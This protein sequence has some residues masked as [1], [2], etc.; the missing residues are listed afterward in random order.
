[1]GNTSGD[2][3]SDEVLR[4]AGIERPGAAFAGGSDAENLTSPCPPVLNPAVLSCCTE[5]PPPKARARAQGDLPLPAGR[6]A[7]GRI[8]HPARPDGIPRDGAGRP[9]PPTMHEMTVPRAFLTVTLP[10]G[11]AE[12]LQTP[13]SSE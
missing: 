1:M 3:T 13:S 7:D 2:A 12:E 5:K 9:T 4:K 6:P 10:V 8:H 11:A